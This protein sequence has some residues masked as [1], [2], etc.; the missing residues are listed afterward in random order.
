MIAPLCSWPALLILLSLKDQFCFAFILYGY[1]PI[2]FTLFLFQRNND[3]SSN[4]LQWLQQKIYKYM[5]LLTKVDTIRE[6]L[7]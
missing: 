1:L 6:S 7:S 4:K 2:R 5:R 3:D